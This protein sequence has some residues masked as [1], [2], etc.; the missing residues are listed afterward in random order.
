MYHRSSGSETAQRQVP[1]LTG[2]AV[3]A[4]AGLQVAQHRSLG[5]CPG[6]PAAARSVEQSPPEEAAKATIWEHSMP[7]G[8]VSSHAPR[9]DAC[10]ATPIFIAAVMSY[11]LCPKAGC[12]RARDTVQ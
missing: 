1:A 8:G 3:V 9:L 4:A 2:A 11:F 12:A 6:S 10:T 5:V 7:V